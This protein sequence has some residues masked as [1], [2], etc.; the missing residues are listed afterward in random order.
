MKRRYGD[1][2]THLTL[3]AK[4]QDFYSGASPVSIFELDTPE[5]YRY[6]LKLWSDPETEPMTADELN[7][8]LEALA[9]S[10]ADVE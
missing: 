3:S 6:T 2:K 4:A 5:G 10:E 7:A 8:E 1:V 9:D